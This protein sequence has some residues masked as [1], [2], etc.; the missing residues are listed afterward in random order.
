MGHNTDEAPADDDPPNL[1]PAHLLSTTDVEIINELRKGDRTKGYLTDATGRHRNS[2][3]DR[4]D[5]LEAGGVIRTVHDA[6][7][8]YTLVDDP[9]EYEDDEEPPSDDESDAA[10]QH[11]D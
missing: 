5:V 4:I 1:M 9:R 11:C 7:A 2:I 3:G 8:L 10:E 6:T